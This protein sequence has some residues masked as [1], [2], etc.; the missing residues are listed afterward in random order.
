MKGR[1]C[2]SIA[3]CAQL[4]YAKLSEELVEYTYLASDA[5]IITCLPVVQGIASCHTHVQIL[6]L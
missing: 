6:K 3:D 4:C 5:C 2:T 1:P